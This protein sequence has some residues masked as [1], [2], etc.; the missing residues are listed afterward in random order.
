MLPVR[1]TILGSGTSAGVPVIGCDC[2]VCTSSDP[3]DQRTRSGACIEYVDSRGQQRVV[4]IDASPDLRFQ[5]LRHRLQRC[6]GILFTHHHVDHS[7]GLDEV[8]R[9]NAVMD[10]PIDIYAEE[11]TLDN[12]RR[13][14]AHIFDSHKNV[15]ASFVATLIPHLIGPSRAIDLHGLRFTPLRLMHGRLPIVGFRIDREAGLAAPADDPLPLAY[16]TDVSAIPPETWPALDGLKTLFLDAL[17]YRH[18]P[19]HFTVDQAIET[20]QRIAAQQT[21]L[22]HMTHD[23]MHGDLDARLPDSIRLSYDGLQVGSLA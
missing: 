11:H 8:R 3:R 15:N 14:Y 1:F 19:T 21:Y 13:V 6:D 23:I 16:C 20:A 12:L 9:F 22:V 5:A 4:L 17:R 2:E 10:A 7:F 18:H